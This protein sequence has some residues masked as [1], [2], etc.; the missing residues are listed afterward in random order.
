MEH[1]DFETYKKE[2]A[3][4]GPINTEGYTLGTTALIFLA[5]AAIVTVCAVTFFFFG[6]KLA[7]Y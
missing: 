6:P 2:R 4:I 7:G 5:P 1:S 3:L